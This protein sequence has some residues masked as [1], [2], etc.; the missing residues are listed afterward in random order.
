MK[1]ARTISRDRPLIDRGKK[2]WRTR[3]WRNIFI[4]IRVALRC[5][6]TRRQLHQHDRF[7]LGVLTS[8]ASN[9]LAVCTRM[10][11]C[12]RARV[13]LIHTCARACVSRHATSH[14]VFP[15]ART[16]ADMYMCATVNDT[17]D[18][19]SEFRPWRQRTETTIDSAVFAEKP[20]ERR[21]R[22][23]LDENAACARGKAMNHR[24]RGP[25]IV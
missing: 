15:L 23:A 4:A 13:H 5:G 8:A 2:Q 14:A 19:R 11:T 17:F 1:I 18:S 7:P 10:C 24:A 3:Q 6:A 12:A 21:R 25:S 16:H 22:Q 20:K 9:L